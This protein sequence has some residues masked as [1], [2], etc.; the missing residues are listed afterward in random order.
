MLWYYSRQVCGGIFLLMLFVTACAGYVYLVNARRSADDPKKKHYPLGAIFLTP[1]I[2]PF[3]LLG[4]F[5][6]IVIRAVSFVVLLIL[7]AIALVAIRK[8]FLFIW[9][10]KIGTWVGG[11]L[12]DANTFLIKA[13]FGNGT[14]NP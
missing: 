8:S 12:L 4:A 3:L 14:K 11:R 13:A 9:L 6:E 10:D 5:A 1:F 7:F 2:W